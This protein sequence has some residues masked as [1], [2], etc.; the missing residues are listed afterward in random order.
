MFSI[1]NRRVNITGIEQNYA[2]IM[3][4]PDAIRTNYLK[5]RVYLL[6]E[7]AAVLIKEATKE[8]D[9]LKFDADLIE[10]ANQEFSRFSD[11]ELELTLMTCIGVALVKYHQYCEEN[12]KDAG[13]ELNE[14]LVDGEN[15]NIIISVGLPNNAVDRHRAN[16]HEF[17]E[18]KNH[19]FVMEIGANKYDIDVVL[20]ANHVIVGSQ[21]RA[22]LD[23]IIY[24]D[25]GSLCEER[26]NKYFPAIIIDGG[27]KTIVDF[28]ATSNLA[29]V[30][31]P[32]SE[33]ETKQYAMG[34][35]SE[36]RV[37]EIKK[38]NPEAPIRSYN[39]ETYLNEKSYIYQHYNKA[40]KEMHTTNL[41][42]LYNKKSSE[43]A[44][45]YVDYLFDKYDAFAN[46]KGVFFVGGTGAE[47]CRILKPA[48]VKKNSALAENERITSSPF[49]F[50]GKPVDSVYVVTAGLYK[51]ILA[52]NN[53]KKNTSNN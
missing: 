16:I 33:E 48:I 31:W 44:D 45:N 39:I 49:E 7:Q 42:E 47:Y 52:V 41:A 51:G 46:I 34:M 4:K 23:A 28:K 5:N 24:N 8:E 12:G 50:N 10:D 36:E 11:E 40:E 22:A 25:D 20:S 14:R 30:N 32:K 3:S 38:E 6:G 37:K 17:L 1:P 21:A 29:T 35:L 2:A 27:Y 9:L 19:P 43:L 26:I 15:A 13:Y 53:S 18:N